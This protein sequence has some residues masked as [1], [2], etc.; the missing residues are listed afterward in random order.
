MDINQEDIVICTTYFSNVKKLPKDF[1]PI[2]I[3]AKPPAGW[4]YPQ[5]KV[6]SPKYSFFTVWKETH[7]NDYYIQHFNDEVLSGLNPQETVKDILRLCPGYKPP[8]I[9][10]VCYETPEKFCHRHLVADWLNKNG[11]NVAEFIS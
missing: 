6:L 4:K 5:Y 7:D 8:K 3:A 2:S 1:T 11:F 10:L 9:A